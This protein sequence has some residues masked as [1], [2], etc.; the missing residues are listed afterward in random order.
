M[1]CPDFTARH[2]RHYQYSTS[3]AYLPAARP[4]GL[5]GESESVACVGQMTLS[6]KAIWKG[7]KK[8]EL[9]GVWSSNSLSEKRITPLCTINV[10]QRRAG[11]LGLRL[12]EDNSLACVLYIRYTPQTVFG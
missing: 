9:E 11:F 12:A 10:Q 4:D 6:T 5:R 8:Q 2:N 3:L 7:C 1:A